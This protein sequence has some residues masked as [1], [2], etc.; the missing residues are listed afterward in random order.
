M[1][2]QREAVY[3]AT[4]NVLKEH[5]IEFEDGGNITEVMTDTM[6]AEVIAIVV[7]GFMQKTVELKDTPK[8]KEKLESKAKM[9][10]YTSGLVS[11]WYRKDKRFNGGVKYE[12][13]NPGS[14]QGQGDAKLKALKQLKV[15]F[16]GTDQE[17]TIDGHIEARLEEIAAEKAAKVEIDYSVLDDELLA[18]LGIEVS[19]DEE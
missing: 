7:E 12:P 11:N 1:L 18:D 5:D 9:Q 2:N 17:A 14:R 3:Q 16:S 10:S 8:N 19:E 13:K 15:K 6:R 4:R